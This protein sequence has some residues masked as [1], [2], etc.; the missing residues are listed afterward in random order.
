VKW[1]DPEVSSEVVE[2]ANGTQL[3]DKQKIYALHRV[4]RCPSQFPFYRRHTAFFVDLTDMQ[5]LDPE[6]TVDNIIRDQVDLF[7]AVCPSDGYPLTSPFP[8]LS[9]LGWIQWAAQP[10]RWA[11]ARIFFRLSDD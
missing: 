1:L 2:F 7:A 6:M 4:K 11:F 5:D 3:T 8:G 10:R 9:L